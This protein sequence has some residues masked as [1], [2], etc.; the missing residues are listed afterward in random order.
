[1]NKMALIALFSFA[2]TCF[3][4]NMPIIPGMKITNIITCYTSGISDPNINLPTIRITYYVKSHLD[5]VAI[6][7]TFIYKGKRSLGHGFDVESGIE[8]GLENVIEAYGAEGFKGGFPNE[9]DM[10]ASVKVQTTTG[11]NTS[12]FK[13]N[14]YTFK[15]NTPFPNK[16]CN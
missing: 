7:P 16:M 9:G 15:W 8:T 13:V 5:T 6:T 3:S 4:S 14:Y 11:E 2:S 10:T 1:M 12:H